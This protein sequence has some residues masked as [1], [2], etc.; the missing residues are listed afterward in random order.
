MSADAKLTMYHLSEIENTITLIFKYDPHLQFID[1]FE[2]L[3]HQFNDIIQL[4]TTHCQNEREYWIIYDAVIVLLP[5]LDRLIFEGYSDQILEF[6]LTLN[7]KLG[8]NFIFCTS[9]FIPLRLQLFTTICSAFANTQESREKDAAEFINSFKDELNL[10]KQLEESNVNGLSITITLCNNQ[11]QKLSDLFDVAYTVINLMS[12]HFITSIKID[13]EDKSKQKGQQPKKK[14]AQKEKE[15][16]TSQPIPIPSMDTAQLIINAFNSPLK[17]GEY[18]NK[19]SSII[20]AWTNPECQ[21]G[22]M[23][24]YRLIFSF[25]KAGKLSTENLTNLKN[26]LPDDLIVQLSIAISEEKWQDISD[27]LFQ[28]P[29]DDIEL[30]FQFFNEIALK[31]WNRFSSGKIEDPMVLKGVLHIL[32]LSPSSDPI[33]TALTAL[34]YTWHLDSLEMYQEAIEASEGAIDVIESYRDIFSTRKTN[35]IV[36]P[37]YRIPNSPHSS[38]TINYEKWIECLHTDLL[39]IW[40][41]SKLKRG[42]Q[43]DIELEKERYSQEMEATMD[44]CI[45]TKKLNGILSQKQQQEFDNL[46][47][48]PFKHPIHSEATEQELMTYFKANKAGKAL[49][50]TQMSFFRPQKADALLEK[51][52]Q[53]MKEHEKVQKNQKLNN[54]VLFVNRSEIGLIFTSKVPGE[55]TVCVFG[56][57]VVGATGLTTQNTA[58]MGT[59]V[60]QEDSEPFIISKLKANTEYSFGF[61]AYDSSNELIDTITT[62]FTVT[63]YHPLCDEM[64]WSYIASASYQLGEMSSFDVALSSL[65]GHFTAVSEKGHD[66]EYFNNM[67]PFNRFDLKKESFEEP[68]PSLRAF[69]TSLIM[70][71]RLF[72]SS[73][74]MHATAFQKVALI[75]SVA[76]KNSQL[77]LSVC[78]EIMATIYPIINNTFNTSWFVSPLLYVIDT[79]RINKETAGTE[80]HQSLLS[81]SSFALDS[82][83]VKLYQEK[84]IVDLVASS[85]LEMPE[86]Q[87][88]TNFAL[89]ASKNRFLPQIKGNNKSSDPGLQ[90][91][92]MA[93]QMYKANPDKSFDDF[94]SKYKNDDNFAQIAVF[95]ISA[96]HNEGKF[97]L[98]I[99]WCNSALDFLRSELAEL[100]KKKEEQPKDESRS[101]SKMQ[102]KKKPAKS[103]KNEPPPPTEEELAE[104]KAS[105]KIKEVWKRYK[106]RYDKNNKF[107]QLNKFR[108][109][110]NLFLAICMIETDQQMIAISNLSNSFVKIAPPAKKNNEKKS[111]PPRQNVE[112]KATFITDE[113]CG[114]DF[115]ESNNRQEEEEESENDNQI[116]RALRRSI[117]LANRSDD[118]ITIKSATIYCQ[119]YISTIFK[120]NENNSNSTEITFGSYLASHAFVLIKNA[121]LDEKSTQKLLRE[122]LLLMLKK[123]QIDKIK[124]VL[125]EACQMSSKSGNLI[126][127]IENLLDGDDELTNALNDAKNS[128]LLRR[129]NSDNVFNQVN[130]ILKKIQR[131]SLFPDEASILE[132]DQ[133][134]LIK[135]VTDASN[136]LQKKLKLSMSVSL[137]TKLSFLLYKKGENAIATTKL[138]EALE[139]HFKMVKAFEKVETI[140]KN[141]TEESFYKEHSWAG[142]LSIFVISSLISMNIDKQQRSLPHINHHLRETSMNLT[143]LAAFALSS[144][145]ANSPLNPK[146]QVDFAEFE[147]VEIVPG[148]DI[149]SDLDPNQPLLEAPPAEFVATSI[150]HLIS[151]MES[152]ELYF[153]MFKPL[154]FARHFFRF[155]VRE[156]RGLARFRLLTVMTCSR[157]G[158]L[159]S[160]FKILND[161]IT[162]YGESKITRESSLYNDDSISKRIQFISSEP[163]GSP[164]NINAA[165]SISTTA[166]VD[167]ISTQYGFPLSCLF[168]VSVSRLLQ[169]IAKSA[170]PSTALNTESF[171]PAGNGKKHR[172]ASDKSRIGH[173]P[174]KSEESQ[175]NSAASVSNEVFEV[176]MKAC[177]ALV[178]AQVAK[179]FTAE[180][181][182]MKLELVLEQAVIC[183]TLWKWED[184]ISISHSVLN[185]AYFSVA[186][187]LTYLNMSALNPIG[188][189]LVAKRIICNASYNINDY[190]TTEKYASEVSPYHR[191]LVLIRKA[192]FE[193]AAHILTQISMIKPITQFYKEHVLSVAQLIFLF[194]MDTK[195]IEKM[196]EKVSNNQRSL[197]NPLEMIKKLNQTVFSFYTDQLKLNEE[198]SYFL[199]DAHLLV[200]LKHLEALVNVHFKGDVNPIEILAEAQTLLSTR[201]SYVS[202]GLS[203]LLNATVSRIQ[204]QSFLHSSPSLIQL[205]NQDVDSSVLGSRIPQDFVEKMSLLLQTV[206]A[207][208]PDC[209]VHPISQQ[210]IL[211]L[212]ILSG[213][214]LTQNINDRTKRLELSL[215]TLNVA[216]AVR[217][218]R[219]FVQSLIATS[220][221]SYPQA[222]SCP[223]LIFNDNKGCKFREI[224][225]SYYANV[226]SLDLPLFD[227][228]MTEMR[229]LLCFKCFED[230]LSSFKSLYNSNENAVLTMDA[231]QIVG[232]WYKADANIF[233]QHVVNSISPPGNASAINSARSGSTRKRGL[234]SSTVASRN[235]NK[236]NVSLSARG[237]NVG[238][239]KAGSKT[240]MLKGTLFFFIGIIVEYEEKEKEKKKSPTKSPKNGNNNDENAGSGKSDPVKLIPLMIAA[241]QNDLKTCCSDLAEIGVQIDEAARL[242]S[243]EAAGDEA[244]NRDGNIPGSARNKG[245]KKNDQKNEEKESQKYTAA[246]LLKN[247]ASELLSNAQTKW[248]SALLKAETVFNKSNRIIGYLVEN[249]DKWPSEVKMNGIEMA[250]STALSHFFNTQYGINEKA[251]QL[252]EWLSKSCSLSQQLNQL[253]NQH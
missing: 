108:A 53:M 148:F 102:G 231:G 221:D 104:L 94:F 24:L 151:S 95:L 241:Q 244:P 226:C 11:K 4:L 220:P 253:Q 41:R 127:I 48:R 36:P 106:E 29:Y 152:Y 81:K 160:A 153:E 79:L 217:T 239:R 31:I 158:L 21:L 229:T 195:L 32:V 93:A 30:D 133:K 206:F 185:S 89:F 191:A 124:L 248:N 62:P 203:F 91:K 69:V 184:A 161:V 12:V 188:F 49:L 27:I 238:I 166:L 186:S 34:H 204:M 230:Q 157:Y 98:A 58:L 17:K 134:F 183:M 44:E 200:R 252:A 121:S 73:K 15:E 85:V 97:E 165:R 224:A 223:L 35:H 178:T 234:D 116:I 71:G 190:K 51:A 140:L 88:R 7:S 20:S 99:K 115:S 105:A 227:T 28:I 168:V 56:K 19:Y 222:F 76:L 181:S 141:Q 145:F 38:D 72:A 249:K 92:I 176:C 122:F 154:S 216:Y 120:E 119:H 215:A 75:V 144:L 87:L 128:I 1:S 86:S 26:A 130:T 70:A 123:N 103:K 192:D 84:Q 173:A 137:V 210:L 37:T 80:L 52:R 218:S 169:A 167:Q 201:C 208:Y 22:P 10:L 101:Q 182:L 117:V 163:A 138:C 156:K 42:L 196:K 205:W 55:K 8:S 150:T 164:T 100:C 179:E 74:P 113:T 78:N 177:E 187:S 233:T 219:R 25:L 143:R 60:R 198:R 214:S 149:F 43:I 132:K 66:H 242:E 125:S 14:G 155:I 64:I 142:C 237:S 193:G 139:S 5:Y 199:I 147:P 33:V 159:S 129:D 9:R 172:N 174:K 40:I 251:P 110:L 135:R 162:S 202:H 250:N 209:V 225:A 245:K 61:G 83:F 54:S 96:A 213:V 131:P 77:A 65:L 107:Y 207:Q 59:G 235:T 180:Q 170:D 126:W 136:L 212:S 197:L 175:P 146:K 63:T 57:E 211:D 16:E 3:N 228:E 82:V 50:F 112:K 194:M 6:L 246:A 13:F 90:V 18:N 111:R 68:A 118:E 240:M 189:V 247:Q 236:S 114:V 67:N 45:R 47:N 243:P 2:K 39:T 46:L 171:T 109:A 23:I 232:Q